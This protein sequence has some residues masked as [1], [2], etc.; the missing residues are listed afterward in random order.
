MRFNSFEKLA[1]SVRAFPGFFSS[2]DITFQTCCSILPS[3]LSS[4]H[5]G[6]RLCSSSERRNLIDSSTS[7]PSR[8]SSTWSEPCIRAESEKFLTRIFENR[9][10][11]LRRANM[12]AVNCS[13]STDSLIEPISTDHLQYLINLAAMLLFRTLIRN[14]HYKLPLPG[15]KFFTIRAR[16]PRTN[17]LRNF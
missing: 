1:S 3:S 15:P 14:Y 8:Y 2:L 7:F 9:L 16:N 6:P 10:A 17:S 11:D 13:G 5:F 4:D 12:L